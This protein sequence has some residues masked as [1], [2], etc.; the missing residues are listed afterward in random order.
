M[1]RDLAG[2]GNP[3]AGEPAEAGVG[4][5]RQPSIR[6]NPVGRRRRPFLY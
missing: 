4:E 2:G 5:I 6:K 3:S 1:T